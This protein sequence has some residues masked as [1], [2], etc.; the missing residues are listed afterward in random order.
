MF[1]FLTYHGHEYKVPIEPTL[2]K[3]GGRGQSSFNFNVKVKTMP[4]SHARKV[5]AKQGIELQY[6][7]QKAKDSLKAKFN[8]Q[9]GDKWNYGQ[10]V[11]TWELPLECKGEWSHWSSCVDTTFGHYTAGTSVRVFS[12]KTADDKEACNNPDGDMQARDCDGYSAK[13]KLLEDL[14][15]ELFFL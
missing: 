6:T 8:G 5:Y 9:K 10:T 15:N 3:H 1:V 13:A 12:H 7:V 4:D 2:V 14:E 11:A